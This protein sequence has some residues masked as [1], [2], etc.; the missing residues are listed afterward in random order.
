MENVKSDMG[1]AAENLAFKFTIPEQ[2]VRKSN[3]IHFLQTILEMCYVPLLLEQMFKKSVLNST[4]QIFVK[5]QIKMVNPKIGVPK[6]NYKKQLTI[7]TEKW[8]LKNLNIQF[9]QV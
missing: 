5:E 2:I 1:L 9:S 8:R 4:V 6:N 7:T 3:S